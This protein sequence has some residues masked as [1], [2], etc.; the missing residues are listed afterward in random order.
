MDNKPSDNKNSINK[1][2]E[3]LKR[4]Q[5]IMN[6]AK[7]EEKETQMPSRVNL[8]VSVYDKAKNINSQLNNCINLFI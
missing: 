2:I 1:R 6:Q 7:L 5:S 4:T 3:N 8:R